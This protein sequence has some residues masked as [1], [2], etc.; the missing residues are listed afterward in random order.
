[1]KEVAKMLC[2]R[3]P[4]KQREILTPVSHRVRPAPSLSHS[5]FASLGASQ[6]G[7]SNNSLQLPKG[8]DFSI[9]CTVK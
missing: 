3:T 9:G 1:V 5:S 7:Q 6:E 2:P 4:E 8:D